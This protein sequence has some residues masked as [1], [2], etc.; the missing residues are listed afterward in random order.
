MFAING[1]KSV[2]TYPTITCACIHYYMLYACGGSGLACIVQSSQLGTHKDFNVYFHKA[3]N[4][5][6]TLHFNGLLE[7]GTARFLGYPVILI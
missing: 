4:A 6:T 5:L 1:F 2:F 3:L 7:G